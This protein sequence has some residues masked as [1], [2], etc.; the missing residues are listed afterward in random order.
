MDIKNEL[1]KTFS[2][3]VLFLEVCGP[4]QEHLSVID[5]PG[6]FKRTTPGVT[7]KEDIQMIDAMV[8][9]YMENPRSV[10]LA[11]MSA[12]VDIATEEILEMAQDVDPDGHRTIGVL[13][14]PDLVDRG[15]E[16]DVMDLINGQ[17]HMLALGWHLVRNPGQQEMS[18]PEMSEDAPEGTFFA[19]K[20]PW[21]LLEKDKVGIPA[22]KV[23]LR[24]IHATLTLREFP[25]VSSP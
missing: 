25:K 14:K 23:R 1:F 9:R 10:I 5:V 7:S 4:E 21:N 8:Q 22:L 15:V 3:D 17:R 6:I 13:T 20:H 24:D 19:N 12:N 16:V 2:D 11:V 18:D